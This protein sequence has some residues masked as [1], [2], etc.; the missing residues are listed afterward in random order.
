MLTPRAANKRTN[1]HTIAIG[2]LIL[3]WCYTLIVSRSSRVPSKV[4]PYAKQIL[5]KISVQSKTATQDLSHLG[6]HVHTEEFIYH[7][8][9]IKTI[10]YEGDRP[11]LTRINEPLLGPPCTLHKSNL[12]NIFIESPELLTL[13]VPRSPKVDT[14]TMS[15]GMSTRIHRLH[16]TIPQLAHWL[17]HSG[18]QLHIIAPPHEDDRKMELE[19]RNLG[20]DAT[21]TT[22]VAPSPKAYFSILKKL[23]DTRTPK[24]KWLVLLDDDTFVT[25]LPY[26]ISH[27]DKMYDARKERLVGAL[28]DNIGQIQSFGLLP[29]GG[30]GVFISV[31]LAEK[32]TV[33]GTW[34]ECMASGENTGDGMVSNCLNAFSTVRP[35]FDEGLNQMDIV[36][37]PSGYFESGRRMLTIH[38]WKSWFDVNVPMVANVSKACGDECVL[39]RWQFDD[40]LVLSNGYSINEYPRGIDGIEGEGV[41][42]KIELEKVEKTWDGQ[43]WE[44]IHKIGPLR[45]KLEEEE[46]RTLFLVDASVVDG[47]NGLAVGVRQTY[48]ENAKRVDGIKVGVDRVVQLFWLFD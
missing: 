3:I 39:Q 48:V 2:T 6:Q 13:R 1:V 11:S 46:K 15:F 36:G 47:V 43:M 20:I 16:D 21:I 7:Q 28:S 4:L 37:D 41:T 45:E 18:A 31:P 32:L 35:T 38:H 17:P 26:L 40:N 24:T 25:S 42:R 14:S 27:F 10:Y 30:G 5:S 33:D 44:Y 22:A 29:F 34:E 23:Y 8:R 19:I 9:T 12:T